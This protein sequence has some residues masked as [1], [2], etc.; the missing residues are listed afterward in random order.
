MP[1]KKE[2]DETQATHEAAADAVKSAG[3]PARYSNA[4]LEQIARDNPDASLSELC[5]IAGGSP[6]GSLSGRFREARARL[7]SG[8]GAARAIE[9]L[10]GAMGAMGR[11]AGGD[12]EITVT[13]SGVDWGQDETARWEKTDGRSSLFMRPRS[14]PQ[15]PSAEDRMVA[16]LDGFYATRRPAPLPHVPAKNGY[17]LV[18]ISA[19]L[20]LGARAV[21]GS[22]GPKIAV[23]AWARHRDQILA[24]AA[25]LTGGRF[26]TLYVQGNDGNHTDTGYAT[27]KGTPQLATALPSEEADEAWRMFAETAE[28]CTT[29]GSVHV[30]GVTGNHGRNV[31][32][33]FLRTVCNSIRAG[34]WGAGVTAEPVAPMGAPTFVLVGDVLH[35]FRHFDGRMSP[36]RATELANEVLR[37]PLARQ[38]RRFAVHG[39]HFHSFQRVD[40]AGVGINTYPTIKPQDHYHAAEG[41][42]GVRRMMGILYGPAGFEM[43]ILSDPEEGAQ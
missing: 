40:V 31:E 16:A 27:T 21:D 23:D 3:R 8:M 10:M 29:Y 36:A 26:N 37:H 4:H 35:M 1:N 7:A 2:P 20:H 14:E 13:E 19:D 25:S 9:Q 38:A 12:P 18:L 22:W 42:G 5:R 33:V 32:E 43:V 6:G 24:R 17:T 39:G 34:H 28:A 11:A 15:G 41:Y 30:V